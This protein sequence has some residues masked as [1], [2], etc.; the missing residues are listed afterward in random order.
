[1]NYKL[2]F[3]RDKINTFTILYEFVGGKLSF[4]CICLLLQSHEWT[5]FL[6]SC[7]PSVMLCSVIFVHFLQAVVMTPNYYMCRRQVFACS[8]SSHWITCSNVIRQT[9]RRRR[10][11]HVP[12]GIYVLNDTRFS[13]EVWNCKWFLGIAVQILGGGLAA[14]LEAHTAVLPRAP[15]TACSQHLF[16]APEV[17]C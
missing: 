12:L 8:M 6:Y 16:M 9:R 1:M 4:L 13:P 2:N 17:S 14:F 7:C 10:P 3:S 5:F 15:V 11:S